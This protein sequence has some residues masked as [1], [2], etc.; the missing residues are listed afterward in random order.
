VTIMWVVSGRSV[1]GIG[2]QPSPRLVISTLVT[3]RATPSRL[4]LGTLIRAQPR[5]D[6][7]VLGLGTKSGVQLAL[8]LLPRHL[9]ITPFLRLVQPVPRLLC[10][11]HHSAY[12]TTVGRFKGRIYLFL[13]FPLYEPDKSRRGEEIAAC[14]GC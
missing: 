2:P 13:F 12:H 5:F 1:C 9:T 8:H 4:A 3:D 11:E 7:F 6:A 10:F 14:H